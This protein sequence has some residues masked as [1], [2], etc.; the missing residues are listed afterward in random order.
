MHRTSCLH[1]VNINEYKSV[2]LRHDVSCI[3]V[4]LCFIARL[5]RFSAAV[6]TRDLLVTEFQ[7]T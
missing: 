5:S 3:I 2:F 7:V 4:V 1:I 6:Q